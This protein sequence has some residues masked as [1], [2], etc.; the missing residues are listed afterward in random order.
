[1][2]TSKSVVSSTKHVL[3][4]EHTFTL[5]TGLPENCPLP[6]NKLGTKILALIGPNID[7][8]FLTNYCFSNCIVDCPIRK[9][10]LS[11]LNK[12]KKE[13]KEAIIEYLSKH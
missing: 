10:T 7:E 13:I 9:N 2:I 6:K 4:A 5:I 1:I 8:V 3:Q 11:E 12:T